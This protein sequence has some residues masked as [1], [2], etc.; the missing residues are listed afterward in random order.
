[1]RNGY[2]KWVPSEIPKENVPLGVGS[3]PDLREHPD[4]DAWV[5]RAPERLERS[6]ALSGSARMAWE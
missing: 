4:T 6:K 3:G 5:Q 1:M 2:N